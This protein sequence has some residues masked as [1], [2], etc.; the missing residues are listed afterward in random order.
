MSLIAPPPGSKSRVLRHLR[1]ML[2]LP[3]KQ[4][5]GKFKDKVPSWFRPDRQ[6]VQPSDRVAYWNIVPGDEVV[7]RRG[8]AVERKRDDGTVE[9]KRFQ[10][11]VASVDR[12]TNV[13]Y[14]TAPE[15]AKDDTL[16][17]RHKRHMQPMLRDREKPEE[18]YLPNMIFTARPIHYSNLQLKLPKDLQLPKDVNLDLKAGVLAS[19]VMRSGVR[20]DKQRGFFTWKRYAV[21]QTP[22][23]PLQVEVPWK[24]GEPKPQKRQPFATSART[25]DEETWIPWAPMDPVWLLPR[26]QRTSPQA[27]ERYAAQLRQRGVAGVGS[28]ET[29]AAAAAAAG[30]SSSS[31][32]GAV[33]PGTVASTLAEDE[34]TSAASSAVR[35][36]RSQNAWTRRQK[37][38][39]KPP[40]IPQPPTA[41]EQIWQARQNAAQWATELEARA[42]AEVEAGAGAAK[43]IGRP[44]AGEKSD[45]GQ[46]GD[47]AVAATEGTPNA[48]FSALDYLSMAPHEGPLSVGWQGLPAVPAATDDAGPAQLAKQLR[49]AAT[50]GR[51]V[52]Q[53]RVSKHDIDAWPIELL[54]K[55]DLINET[56]TKHRRRRWHAK[57]ARM[58]ELHRLVADEEQHNVEALRG[59]EL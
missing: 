24:K 44:S 25:V 9:R 18:G 39:V 51:L 55:D 1:H 37:R 38:T 13:A 32:T 7:V 35:F 2:P 30:A 48:A 10:G 58:Q 45:E 41:A 57:Q 17:P 11:I 50:T 49:R 53:A 23:G 8:W 4:P 47:E 52:D 22:D 59:L 21:V 12:N 14:L 20:Y 40:P 56:G 31:S 46:P 28:S 27:L 43:A 6:F 29:A 34:T 42:E 16:I 19:R 15:D 26:K 5:L 36:L 3:K 54:M 33:A